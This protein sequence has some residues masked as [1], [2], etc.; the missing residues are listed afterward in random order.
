MVVR[1]KPEVVLPEF[2][3]FLMVSDKFMHRAVEISVGSLSPTINWT[4]LKHEEFDLPPLDQQRR[5]AEILWAVDEVEQTHT[6]NSRACGAYL[7]ASVETMLGEL[8]SGR[9]QLL[10]ALWPRSPNSGCSAPPSSNETGHYVLSLT[11]LSTTGYKSGNL[12]PVPP[13]PAML[14][15]RLSQGDL[16]ISRSNTQELVGLVGI[17]DEDRN[18]VSFADTM[19]RMHVDEQQILKPF[20]ELVLLSARGRRHMKRSAAGTSGSMKKINRQTLGQCLV[21][22]PPIEVQRAL[23]E[24]SRRLRAATRDCERA[25]TATGHLKLQLANIFVA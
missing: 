19:I 18:D 1:A 15:A 4:T 12:K 2:L 11:A 21:P 10:S 25:I 6:V 16:L 13:T 22:T 24:Q 14:N 3:P 20:L 7:T 8:F 17:F 9:C 5:I 23:L